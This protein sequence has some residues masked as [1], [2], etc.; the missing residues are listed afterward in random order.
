MGFEEHYISKVLF[1]PHH[2]SG[3][4][5]SPK[6]ITGDFNLDHLVKVVS[7]CFFYCK[8]TSLPFHTLFF[9]GESL[10]PRYTQEEGIEL[11]LLEGV[12]SMCILLGILL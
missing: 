2:L 3:S 9:L 7:I 8:V 1:L 5:I 10:N 11:H 4:M 6:F 12:V